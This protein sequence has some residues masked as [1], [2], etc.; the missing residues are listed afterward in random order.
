GV[1]GELIP[2]GETARLADTL[3]KLAYS[4]KKRTYY[5]T[6][7][8]KAVS[9]DR[10]WDMAVYRY[11]QAYLSLMQKLSEPGQ[12]RGGGQRFTAP[13]RPTHRGSQTATQVGPSTR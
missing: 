5:G 2:A 7:G 12:I 11:H 1:S 8:R 13:P 3:T 10:T 4:H 9:N 6:A